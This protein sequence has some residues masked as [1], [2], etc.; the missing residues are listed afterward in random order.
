[1]QQYGSG[2]GCVD[3]QGAACEGAS[4]RWLARVLEGAASEGSCLS[5]SFEWRSR[6]IATGLCELQQCGSQCVCCQHSCLFVLGS[7]D[8]MCDSRAA[9]RGL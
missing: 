7:W 2:G 8:A 5:N 4:A 9:D 1:M 6:V 3:I